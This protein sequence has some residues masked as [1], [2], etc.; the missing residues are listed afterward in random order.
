M[1]ESGL[2]TVSVRLCLPRCADLALAGQV[3][4]VVHVRIP[5]F[6]RSWKII[7]NPEKINFSGKSWKSHGKLI[8]IRKSWKNKKII[9]SFGEMKKEQNFSMFQKDNLII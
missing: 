7:E 5:R 3:I 1:S 4:L 6:A 8:K 2:V 9:K